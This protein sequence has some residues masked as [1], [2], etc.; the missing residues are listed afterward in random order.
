VKGPAEQRRNTIDVLGEQLSAT[1]GALRR[2]YTRVVRQKNALLKDEADHTLVE[3]WNE[4]LVRLGA[5]LHAH[6]RRLARRVLDTAAP[7]YAHFA[8][9]ESLDIK[10]C[11]RCELEANDPRDEIDVPALESS[12]SAELDRRRIE[13]RGRKQA[14]VGPPRDDI[15]FLIDGREARSFASQGQQRTIALAWKWAEV[16]LVTDLLKKKPVLLLDDVMS[17]LDASRRAALTDLVQQDVQTFIT[18][19]TTA[20]FDHALLREARVVELEAQQ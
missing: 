7:I 15:T 6:R 9:R 18:T 11:D 1:Y 14:L 19:T 17:E 4:Q 20:Y 3:P 8:D 2:D 10:M 13:E 16:A 5:R 12:I